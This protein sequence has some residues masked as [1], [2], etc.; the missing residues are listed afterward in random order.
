MTEKNEH[1]ANANKEIM[2]NGRRFQINE[3]GEVVALDG[4]D[5]PAKSEQKDGIEKEYA[6]LDY[7]INNHPDRLEDVEAARARRDKLE[8]DLGIDTQKSAA[9][10]SKAKEK[11]RARINQKN[12]ISLADIISHQKQND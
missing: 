7:L 5:V 1:A 12:N 8:K 2:M 10:F 3:Y 4:K 6:N 9:A 11:L